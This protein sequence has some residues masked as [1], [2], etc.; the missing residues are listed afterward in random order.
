[1]VIP[2]LRAVDALSGESARASSPYRIAEAAGYDLDPWQRDVLA[3][4]KRQMILLCSRQS[5]KSTVTSVLA[6][7]E[8]LSNPGALILLMAPAERQSLELFRKIRLAYNAARE[9]L[10]ELKKETGSEWEFTNSS[11]IVCLPG[12]EQTIRGYS[13]AS[14][15]VVDEASRVPDALYSSI[16]PM[17]A[18]SKGRIVLLSTPFG[19]RGFFFQEWTEG[20]PDWHRAKITAYECPRIDPGWLEQERERIGDWWFEQ[21]YFCEFKEAE[22]AVFR[23]SDIQRALSDPSVSP[24]FPDISVTPPRL[25]SARTDDLSVRP[26]F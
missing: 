4:D 6:L 16:R 15:L 10:P 24:M 1:M 25:H 19:K 12:K 11:R 26:M 21:E 5:G 8:A 14:L 13:G 23:H 20:G 9:V 7:W 17:L 3:S 18:V 2:A 22:D